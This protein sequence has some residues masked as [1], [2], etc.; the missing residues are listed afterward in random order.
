MRKALLLAG[1]LLI[2]SACY[3][4]FQATSTPT[5]DSVFTE[6]AQ[7][8]A[9]ELT[10]VAAETSAAPVIPTDTPAPVPTN[11]PVFT[12]TNT[13]I[14]CLLVGFT[15][16]TIDQTV[17][18]NTVMASGQVFV[19]TWRLINTG[20]CTWNS[21]YQLVFD[22][23][24]GMGAVTG[25]AQTLTAGTVAPGQ[26]V[27]VSVTLTAPAA[28]GTYTGYWRFRDPN[29][30]YFGIGGAGTW[31]VKIIV[32]NTVTVTL[33]PVT[34]ISGT[35]RA[36]AGPWPD[37]TIG[38]SNTDITQTTEV[39]LTYDISGIP[40]NATITEAK[41]DFRSYSVT[42]NPFGL[43]TL[44]GFVTDYGGTLDGS[45]FVA[46]LPGGSTLGWT[47]T[48]ML[49]SLHASAE[50]KAAIQSKLGTGRIQWR[51][52]FAGSNLDAVKDRL[53]LTNPTFIVTYT[54]P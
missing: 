52:Q 33:T 10:R 26:S 28:P 39:F 11:T 47:S 32:R 3:I 16:A 44:F 29:G 51:L 1:I 6:A 38:E 40:S 14:P 15:N 19:K 41:I 12:P 53:S 48:G 9:A 17:P 34:G 37:Y 50:L 31:I 21:S 18:D 22:H 36:G 23:G 49:D 5:S 24:D 7:T 4:P 2:T 27:D 20:T 42:G 54:T 30:I 13:P 8:V 46:G 43:G 25:Y 35:I 45:D